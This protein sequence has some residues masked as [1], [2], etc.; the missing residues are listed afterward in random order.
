MTTM[1]ATEAKTKFGELES[2]VR[3]GPVRV[4]KSGRD[5]MVILSAEEYD[6]LIELE[7]RLWGERALEAT[8]NQKSLGVGAT[9]KWLEQLVERAS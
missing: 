9:A 5:T 8:R 2:Q 7:D 4:T 6:R 1:T 3:T